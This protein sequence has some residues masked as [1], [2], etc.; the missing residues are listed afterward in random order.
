MVSAILYMGTYFTTCYMQVKK[1]RAFLVFS[2]IGASLV[3]IIFAFLLVPVWGVVGALW[4]LV[5]AM[6]GY[7]AATV[8]YN[9]RLHAL[10]RRL[11]GAAHISYENIVGNDKELTL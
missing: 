10:D 7:F 11:Y 4:A 5:I 3:N 6:A 1:Q 8:L 2:L 9:M